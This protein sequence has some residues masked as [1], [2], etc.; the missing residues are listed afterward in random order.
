MTASGGEAAATIIVRRPAPLWR[1][2][3][4]RYRIQVDGE[5]IGK[6]RGGDEVAV[7]VAPGRHSIRARIDWTG[8]P[9]VDVDVAAGE[10]VVLTV[11]PAGSSL[12]LDQV[13]GSDRYL[14]LKRED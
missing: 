12:R 2:G 1:D 5:E 13:F 10:H 6:V 7:T 9:D 3:L 11:E 4:R 8:S 14:T